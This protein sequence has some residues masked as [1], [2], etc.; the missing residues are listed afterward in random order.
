MRISDGSSYVCS[1]DLVIRGKDEQGRDLVIGLEYLTQGLRERAAELFSLDLGP[2][3]DIEIENRLALE[4]EQERLTSIDRRL[5]RSMDDDRIV[6]VTD[7]DP[8][9]PS[10]RAGRLQKLGHLGLAAEIEPGRWQLA[11]G[12]DLTLRRTGEHGHIIRPIQRDFPEHA[13]QRVGSG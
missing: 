10:L 11:E 12:M 5:L 13:R 7:R 2:R 6:A 9:H 8:F 1:S 3:T 4:I